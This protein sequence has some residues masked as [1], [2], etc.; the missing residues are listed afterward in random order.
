MKDPDS[1]KHWL[2]DEEAAE[3]V[4]K[5]FDLYINGMG[6]KTI[7]KYLESNGVLSPS[8]YLKSKGFPTTWATHTDKVKW[9]CSTVHQIVSRQEY[10]GDVINFK[11]TSKSYKNHKK[12]IRP[13]EERV[14]LKGVNEPIIS[15]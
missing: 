12:I 4:R 3:V 1:K 8:E 7:A 6:T 14:I 11:T 13:I 15:V 5:I 9:S 10:I 2:I